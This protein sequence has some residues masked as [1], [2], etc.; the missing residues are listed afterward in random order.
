MN[1]KFLLEAAILAFV[2]VPAT[3]ATDEGTTLKEIMQE[4]RNNLVDIADG[5]LTDDY[6]QVALG[7]S[8]IAGHPRI[9]PPQVQLVAAELGTEM[10]AFKQLD[11]LVHD[12]S[13]D[14][15]AAAAAGDRVAAET[16]YQRMIDG[17]FA[18]HRNYK[19]R[20]AA[21]LNQAPDPGQRGVDQ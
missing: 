7:A 16:G 3:A 6:E 21:V 13:L 8:A 12:L 10:A 18:C 11:M 5:L 20:I 14:I 17:C 2:I 15:K 19:D 1:R 4:L 9:P